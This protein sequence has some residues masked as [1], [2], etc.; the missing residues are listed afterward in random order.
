MQLTCDVGGVEDS[1]NQYVRQ[2]NEAQKETFQQPVLVRVQKALYNET[3][4]NQ[5]E[6]GPIF[7]VLLLM[8]H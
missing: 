3:C 4:L 5:T 1:V 8:W 2:E 6:V 7:K